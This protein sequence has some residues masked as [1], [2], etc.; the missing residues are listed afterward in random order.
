MLIIADKNIP[1]LRACCNDTITYLPVNKINQLTIKQADVLLIRTR[2]KANKLLLNNSN[3]N[4]IASATIGTD[5][6]D[7]NYLKKKS[8]QWTNAPGCNANSVLTYMSAALIKL[9]REYSLQLNKLTIGVIGY[10][11]TGKKTTLLAKS[12]GMNLII[13]DPPLEKEN[14]RDIKFS[15]LQ[16][17]LKNSD[18]IALHIPYNKTGKYETHHLI[19]KKELELLSNDS[20]IINACRGEVISNQSLK[21]AL[22]NKV[23]R[24]SILDVWENEPNIDLEL[25]DNVLL[26]TPHIAGYSADGK[27]N[28]TK[29]LINFINR[30]YPNHISDT[31]PHQHIPKIGNQIIDASKKKYDKFEEL[32]NDIIDYCYNISED[33]KRLKANPEEF[34]KQRNNYPIRRDFSYYIIKLA[35]TKYLSKL[36]DLGFQ[37]SI[38]S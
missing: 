6:L 27:A 3:V 33:Y 8:I 32:L 31:N 9:K 14:A 23:I 7:K 20:F 13:N 17:L 21:L 28:A 24:Q 2:T 25:L 35:N 11:N 22:K 26:A 5:H 12:L 30:H 10:G 34:E 19:G 18:I 1:F 15:S 29:V 4:L 37:T 36:E 16:Y 38:T